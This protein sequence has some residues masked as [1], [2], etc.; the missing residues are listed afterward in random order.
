LEEPV[1]ESKAGHEDESDPPPPEDEEV[2]LV[3]HIVG[4]ETENVRLVG[5]SP[6]PTSLHCAGDLGGKEMAHRVEWPSVVGDSWVRNEAVEGLNS[7]AIAGKF[8]IE[9]GVQY[10]LAD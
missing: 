6:N 7:D 2:V 9:E 1:H 10:A 3:E 4:E 5:I 8:F